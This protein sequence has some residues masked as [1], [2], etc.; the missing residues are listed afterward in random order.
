VTEIAFHFNAPDK[1][2]YACRLLRKAVGSG[3]KVVVTAP[4]DA[5]ARLD[6]AL[7]T[8]SQTE[9]VAHCL[10]SADAA[11]LALSPVVLAVDATQTPHQKVLLN[12]G[13]SIPVG[14][15]RYERLIEV[16]DLSDEDRSLAR[17]RWKQ[18]VQ[19]GYAL[20]RHDLKLKAQT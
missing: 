4:M 1:I 3:S 6:S 20:Q 8:F 15:E 7:W 16:V 12:L 2:A 19:R 14:F 11:L 10:A 9:F 18:Y 13:E 5:L 17:D